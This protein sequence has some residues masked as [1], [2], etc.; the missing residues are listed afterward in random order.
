MRN[1]HD[2]KRDESR[3]RNDVDQLLRSNDIAR[4]CRLLAGAITRRCELLAAALLL[5]RFAMIVID[6]RSLPVCFVRQRSKA[7]IET[8]VYHKRMFS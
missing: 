8:V 6:D 5:D 2:F 1:G 4:A 3:S 7:I